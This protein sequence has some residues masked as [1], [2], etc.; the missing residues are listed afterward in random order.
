MKILIYIQ[1]ESPKLSYT[2]DHIFGQYFD[3]Q[4][5]VTTSEIEYKSHSGPK[6]S[7]GTSINATSIYCST[8]LDKPYNSSLPINIKESIEENPLFVSP[9]KGK[10][11]F[12]FDLFSAIF[13]LLSRYEEYLPSEK[14]KHGRY[15]SKNSILS[16]RD[17]LDPP[18]DRWLLILKQKLET[19]FPNF[20]IPYKN[21]FEVIAT[22][23]IDHYYDIHHKPWYLK[24]AKVANSLRKGQLTEF[25][26]RI[27]TLLGGMDQFDQYSTF[28]ELVSKQK[29]IFF[30]HLGKASPFDE[31]KPI[32][33]IAIKKVIS[34]IKG[35]DC[36]LGIHPSYLSNSSI[37]ALE[38]EL[39][40]FVEYTSSSAT[41]SRQHFLKLSFP[42][43]YRTL[44]SKG[45]NQ[46]YSLTYA[47]HIGF[48]A[49]TAH[50]FFWF[51]LKKDCVTDLRILP[52]A[53]MDVSL[54]QYMQLTIDESIELIKQLKQTCQEYNAPLIFIWHN[55]SMT[56]HNPWK[57]WNKVLNSIVSD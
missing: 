8:F 54:Q 57:G 44:I 12:N 10:Y 49:G 18:I 42:D 46:D 29:K 20:K 32:D 16:K 25:I 55:I 28:L 37:D 1:T 30:L 14:D 22:M 23:D 27:S 7:Y 56:D 9:Q 34:K 52:N 21:R 31:S 5:S 2:L 13:Y 39:N 47:D 19:S 6:L 41:L 40:Q 24:L 43:T 50:P 51:D 48:R 35:L 15:M 26:T 38:D 36:S 4:Y 45:I 17:L 33:H 3:I 53:L 11:L